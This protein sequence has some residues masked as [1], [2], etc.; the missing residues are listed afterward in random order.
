MPLFRLSL[1]A[2]ACLVAAS[3]VAPAQPSPLLR[4]QQQI[5]LPGVEGRIDHLSVDRSSRRVF[6]S[7]LGN[8]TVEAIDLAHG[9]RAG[10]I[11]GLKEPQGVLYAL[12]NSTLYV[13]TGGDGMVRSY[14]S[15]SLQMLKSMPLG[16]D[17]DNVR[18]DAAHNTVLVGYGTG[19][20]A[21]LGLDLSRR[22]DTRLPAHPESFQLTSDGQRAWINLP[23][24]MSIALA[25][26]PH[27]TA[28][29]SWARPGCLAN[30][31]MALDEAHHRV[32]VVCRMPAQLVELDS[33]T[34]TVLQHIPTVGTAD[35]LFYDA[36]RSL[37]Y[38]IG[39]E[40]YVD[41]VRVA[42]NGSLSSAA[43]VPTPPGTRT[44]LLVPQWNQ[45]LVVAPHHGA[46]PA[47]LLVY[48]L[49]AQ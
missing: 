38:V 17:A 49:P 5:P 41:V 30:F 6:L 10:Q 14:D 45:L 25:D 21:E 37:L 29:A 36:A 27:H 28:Q 4:L 7:E 47:R 32:F 42:A 3:T 46:D 22:G 23:R 19:G 1:L 35:D 33:S 39:G 11:H 34:G 24:H 2:L 8:G 44:G 40:G 20:L 43:H 26:L 31:P 9:R 12:A 48:G 16:D 18:Y 15:H 13:A